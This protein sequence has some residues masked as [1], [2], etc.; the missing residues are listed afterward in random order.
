MLGAVYFQ[1]PQLL[2]IPVFTLQLQPA[3]YAA[4]QCASLL[5]TDV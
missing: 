3:A 1:M 4:V 2:A 5:L